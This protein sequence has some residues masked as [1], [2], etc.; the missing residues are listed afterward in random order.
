MRKLASIAAL[1][2]AGCA[3]SGA[4]LQRECEAHHPDFPGLFE[5]TRA[6]VYAK[7]A[8]AL[9]DPRVKLYLLK[10]E[11]LAGQVRDGQIK[12]IDA[13][14]E[15]QQLFVD[16]KAANDAEVGRILATM[17]RPAP[18]QTC[19]STRSPTGTVTTRCE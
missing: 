12:D 2:L 8:D 11:Q 16:L 6:S 4:Q 18:A 1:A 5:C 10:G 19:T 3:T 17:P 15:W 14:V 7:R 13:R 9:S